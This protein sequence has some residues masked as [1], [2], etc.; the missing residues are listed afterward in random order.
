MKILNKPSDT[1][2]ICPYCNKKFFNNKLYSEYFYKN[3]RPK[4]DGGIVYWEGTC[5]IYKKITINCPYCK[6]PIMIKK[7]YYP[8]L[9]KLKIKKDII[10][11]ILYKFRNFI[12]KGEK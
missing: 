12:K 1:F 7:P 2:T 9:F 11:Y 8:L 10:K 5:P 4:L 3:G 6:N